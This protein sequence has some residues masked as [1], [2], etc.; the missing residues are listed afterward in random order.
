MIHH[1]L[2]ISYSQSRPTEC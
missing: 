1:M 2:L